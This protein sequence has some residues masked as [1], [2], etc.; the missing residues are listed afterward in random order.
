MISLHSPWLAAHGKL[1]YDDKWYRR[2]WIIWPQ[3]FAAVLV[4][5]LWAMP[6]SQN[7]AHW[8]KPIDSNARYQQLYTLRES[9]K[10]NQADMDTLERD[11]RGGDMDAQFFVGT[12]YDPDLRLSKITRPD[13]E[14]TADWYG[15]AAA[16]GHQLA[17]N[18]LAIAYSSG[19]F[20]RV[21]YTRACYYALKLNDDAPGNGLNVKGDCYARGLGGTRIDPAQADVAYKAAAAKGVARTSPQ[22]STPAPVTPTPSVMP[23]PFAPQPVPFNPNLPPINPNPPQDNSSDTSWGAMAFTA[24]GSYATIWKM[25][26][27]AEAE[28]DVAKRCAGFGRGRCDV[29]SFSGQECVGLAA[30]E[31]RRI[32]LAYT[33]GGS[34]FPEAQ[35]NALDRCNSDGRTR[36]RCEFRTAVC[37]DGR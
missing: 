24:D 20:T 12:L 18:N 33:A 31:R 2:A 32:R 17:L 4:L 27:Q 30:F 13:F 6:S 36:G 19:R 25:A 28:A 34:T 21:D 9:G 1:W 26:S 23:A 10:S 37:A 5:W 14:K 15:K 35:R 7:S 16:Q 11:A 29:F 3:A 22:P 8:A